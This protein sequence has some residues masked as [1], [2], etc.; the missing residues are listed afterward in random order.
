MHINLFYFQELNFGVICQLLIELNYL[1]LFIKNYLLFY[2][3]DLT[4]FVGEKL[5]KWLYTDSLDNSLEV[6]CII[7]LLDA[8]IRYQLES[9]KNRCETLLIERLEVD[10]CIKI[11]QFSENYNLDRLRNLCTQ[12]VAVRW[13]DFQP[14]HFK[15]MAAL[16]LYELL[17]G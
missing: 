13:K 11:Y 14:H 6:S 5:V 17:K 15:D 3:I 1:V 12:F 2:L 10:N 8:S 16:L 9:L 4:Y 7:S